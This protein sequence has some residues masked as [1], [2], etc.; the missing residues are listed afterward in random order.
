MLEEGERMEEVSYF[1]TDQLPRTDGMFAVV[2]PPGVRVQSAKDQGQTVAR[3]VTGVFARP[4]TST[5][6]SAVGRV[7]LSGRSEM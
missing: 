5:R 2:P 6:V 4:L 7:R 1:C 3:F